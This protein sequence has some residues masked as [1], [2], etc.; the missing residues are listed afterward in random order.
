[1]G[2]E[3]RVEELNRKVDRILLLLGNGNRTMTVADIAEQLGCTRQTLYTSKRYLLPNF[4]KDRK[5]RYTV[6]EVQEWLSRG[7]ANLYNEWKHGSTHQNQ[8]G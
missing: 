1:M 5:H 7:E 4:G 8:E 2:L 3:E 6:S